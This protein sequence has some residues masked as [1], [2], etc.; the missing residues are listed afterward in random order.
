MT[1]GNPTAV[2]QNLETLWASGT[3]T[4]VSDAQLLGRFAGVRDATAETAFRELLRRHSSLVMAVC[5]QILGHSHDADDA[6]QAT[7][8]VLV[9][10]AGSI[11]VRESLAPW[12]YAVA[13]R[14]AQ[15]ARARAARYRSAPVENLEGAVENP[16]LGSCNIDLRPLLHDELNRLPAKYKDPIVLCH[17]E[18]KTHEEA[19]RLL[20]WPVGKLSGRLSRGRDLLRSRLK[21]RGLEVSPSVLACPWLAGTESAVALPLLES[22]VGAAIGIAGT[23]VST[24]ALSL[25]QGVLKTML[26]NKIKT[27][28]LVVL[29]AGGVTAGVDALRIHASQATNRTD[30]TGDSSDP[31]VTI[32]QEISIQGAKATSAPALKKWLAPGSSTVNPGAGA[33][34]SWSRLKNSPNIV[35]SKSLAAIRNSSMILVQSP[36]CAAWDAM[37]LEV[38]QPHWYRFKVQPGTVA[39][40]VAGPD[41]AALAIKGKRIERIAAFDP[42]SGLWAEQM[43]LKPVEDELNPAIGPGWALYQAGNDFY[44]FSTRSEIPNPNGGISSKSWSVLR[45]EGAEE[46]TVATSAEAIEVM[47]GN[48]LY[49]FT[50]KAGAWS[51]PVEAYRPPSAA[52]LKNEQQSGGQRRPR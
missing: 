51:K 41:I 23:A 49:V 29:L 25:T 46:A 34:F 48:R 52:G 30:R 4:G 24:S 43:L 20:H 12:L 10:K 38:G 33:A 39:Q 6:F 27:T 18:G 11:R 15:R 21:R 35:H 40:P 13:Y 26:I 28:A 31:K 9:R 16:E 47:Q 37:S 36:D 17:L 1:R 14:T 50:L 3:L 5:R 2:G 44:A 22:T 8:L 7:F 19:A 32:K 45:L 42:A